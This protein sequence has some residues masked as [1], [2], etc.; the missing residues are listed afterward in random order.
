MNS[1][2]LTQKTIE[3]INNATAMARENDNQYVTAEHLFYALVDADGGL[4]PTLFGRMGVD[5]DGVL[6]ALDGGRLRRG[7]IRH[8]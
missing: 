1:D 7:Q 5:C 6:A 3:T 2:K 4:I 8:V